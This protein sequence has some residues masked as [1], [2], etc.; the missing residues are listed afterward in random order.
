MAQSG[1]RSFETSPPNWLELVVDRI[2]LD[3]AFEA[4]RGYDHFHSSTL[5]GKVRQHQN[6][7]EEARRHFDDAEARYQAI[8]CPSPRERVLFFYL[9]A[10]RFDNAIF[11]E[12]IECGSETRLATDRVLKDL[13]TYRCP[14]EPTLDQIKI[15]I[16]GTYQVLRG[17][18][19]DGLSTFEKLVEESKGRVEDQRVGFFLGA[20]AAAAELGMIETAERH[21][22]NA[23]LAVH[24]LDKNFKLALF[25]SRLYA[26]LERWDRHQE[27]E[28]WLRLLRRL[29]GCEDSKRCFVERAR[30]M[31]EA[32]RERDRI[33]LF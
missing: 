21:Y 2:D 16:I 9:H 1:S 30:I 33:V 10:Y 18:Y 28:D 5:R 22:Q 24:L 25:Y 4:L 3:A 29:P 12:A 15:H 6:L 20:A 7:T 27:A 8:R 26:L 17:E 32:A 11:E 14:D 31:S 13:L 19:E 23:A